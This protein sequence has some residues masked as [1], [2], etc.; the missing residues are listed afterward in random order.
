MTLYQTALVALLVAAPVLAAPGGR[1]E[2]LRTGTYRCELPGDATAG[3]GIPQPAED[4]K[5]VNASSY[6]AGGAIGT[7]LLTGSK[8]VITSGPKRGISYR[9]V[10]GGTLR[11]I[12]HDG[13]DSALSCVR[14]V[15]NNS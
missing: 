3:R 9:R 5:I 7:Y 10:A 12:E 6:G 4:F 8:V 14:A 2:V 11:R 15:A 13:S 1:I